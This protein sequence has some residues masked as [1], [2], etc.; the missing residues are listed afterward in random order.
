MNNNKPSSLSSIVF[1]LLIGLT[2]LYIVKADEMVEG[3]CAHNEGTCGTNDSHTSKEV[4]NNNNQNIPYITQDDDVS[5]YGCQD[6]SEHCE[7]WAEVNECY[8]N[9]PFMLRRCP[10]SC[11]LCPDQMDAHLQ[12]GLDLGVEQKLSSKKY[13]VKQTQTEARIA[14]SR[15]YLQNLDLH[16][17]VIELCKN[18]E[19]SCT[20]WAVAG[21]CEKNPN[22]SKSFKIHHPLIRCIFA[23]GNTKICLVFPYTFFFVSFCCNYNKVKF[24]C[25]AACMSCEQFTI[26][27]RCPVDP[28]AKNAWEPGDLNFMFERLTSEPYLSQYQ[29]EI[30]SR[31]PWVITME[32]VV[33][34]LEADHL[35]QL[36]HEEGYHRSV[37]VGKL[38]PDGRVEE[39]ESAQ[40]TS[41]N[42]WCTKGCYDDFIA[43]IV[44]DR[45]SELVGI[46]ETNAEY[47]QLLR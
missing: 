19:K 37:E 6:K 44:N 25:G 1:L 23:S 43:K 41:T 47:L 2:F 40:R 22:F 12:Y 17:E 11:E 7:Y 15:L 27:G 34:Q 24:K 38:K 31:D 35:I 32:N 28:N 3:T 45:V 26:E 9:R 20:V 5:E 10:R 21:E 46:N 30:L 13:K 39:Y 8:T 4:N 36:G 42:A 33:S 16:E 18:R 29:V 14:E